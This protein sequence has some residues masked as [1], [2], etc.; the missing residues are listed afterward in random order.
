M[1]K[2]KCAGDGNGVRISEA[3]RARREAKRARS[4]VSQKNKN[5][6]DK[7]LIIRKLGIVG[8]HNIMFP[9]AHYPRTSMYC[10]SW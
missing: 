5:A 3:K 7:K 2:R 10:R 8:H 9:V 1:V 4:N 6:S